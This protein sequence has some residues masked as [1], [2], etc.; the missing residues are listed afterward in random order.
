M[1]TSYVVTHFLGK[2]PSVETNSLLEEPHRQ[3]AKEIKSPLTCIII[4]D[5]PMML[6][7]GQTHWKP[8]HRETQWVQSL[9]VSILLQSTR[10]RMLWSKWKLSGTEWSQ[11]WLLVFGINS[12]VDVHLLRWGS[13][14][15]PW[16]K[17]RFSFKSINLEIGIV[18][19]RLG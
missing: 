3:E 4:S 16:G 12:W 1:K 11:G 5:F 18:H 9:Q 6:S 8:E 19:P 14:D 10:R 2:W 17:Q 13:K 15:R 7:F